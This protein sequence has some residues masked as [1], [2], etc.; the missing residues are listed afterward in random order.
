MRW[1]DEY[2]TELREA[3]RR[4]R[5]NTSQPPISLGDVVVIHDEDLP[6]GFGGLARWRT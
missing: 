4:T 1:R 6:R 2:L 5:P 3:H